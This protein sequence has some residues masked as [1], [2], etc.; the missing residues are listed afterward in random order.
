MPKKIIAT[1]K[2]VTPM[3]IGDAEKNA[4]D[5]RP[6][7]VKGALRFWWRA[8]NWGKYLENEKGDEVEALKALHEQEG[9]LFGGLPEI[10]KE[11]DNKNKIKGGQGE[12]LLR[13]K[14]IKKIQQSPSE[15][16]NNSI[17]NLKNSPWQSYLL[18]LGLMKYDRNQRTNFYI[19]GAI[20]SGEFSVELYCRSTKYSEELQNLLI[21]WG[22][23]G[24][25]GSRS[26]KGLGSVSICNLAV[27]GK[28]KTLP[29][30]RDEFIKTLKNLIDKNAEDEPP[31]TAFSKKSVIQ[32]SAESP[33]TPWVALSGIAEKIQMYRGWGHNID[34]HRING[35]R[36]DHQAFQAKTNDHDLVY[37]LAGT[38]PPEKIP[39]SS[40]FGLPRSYKLSDGSLPEI[41]IEAF[42]QNSD[43]EPDS[44]KRSRRA[45]PVFIH[46]HQFPDNKSLIV[47][48]FLPA[49]FLPSQDKIKVLEKVNGKFRDKITTSI[50]EET[51]WQVINE[52]LAL[53]YFKNWAVL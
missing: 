3:F 16:D 1:Y 12:F 33:K 11:K 35:E 48:S 38:H 46:V 40:V 30:N 19:R 9:I 4:S 53:D 17:L 44:H 24:G 34:V 45:S 29:K 43:G 15:L 6:S 2:I 31:Y 26:R 21:F 49:T 23:M 10:I 36:A 14:V 32:I 50:E 51:D 37:E 13:I 47:Q 41:K 18:G 20:V 28:E 8:L 52:Y 22:L 25:L 7:S 27:N 39:K 5:I 42:A